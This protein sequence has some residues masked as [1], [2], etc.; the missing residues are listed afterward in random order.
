MNV[1]IIQKGEVV[2][3]IFG[4]DISEIPVEKTTILVKGFLEYCLS[5]VKSYEVYQH[6][7]QVWFVAEISERG[8][9]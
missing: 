8:V 4:V 1:R 9:I 7:P 6:T 2:M 5:V 3:E